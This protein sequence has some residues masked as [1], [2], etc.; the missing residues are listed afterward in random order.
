MKAYTTELNEAF[1]TPELCAWKPYTDEVWV[2][3]TVPAFAEK[4]RRR[5]DGEMVSYSVAG[6]YLRIYRFA[7]KPARWT[8]SLM[9][10]Y[11]DK[12]GSNPEA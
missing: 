5:K 11:Q 3:T 1:G 12:A 7:G 6:G 10:R 9:A 8:K 2:Q 4:L